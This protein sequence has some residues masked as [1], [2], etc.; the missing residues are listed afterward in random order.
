MFFILSFNIHSPLSSEGRS[1]R[2]R[3]SRY[4]LQSLEKKGEAG[5]S[6]QLVERTVVEQTLTL[7]SM[8]NPTLA[9]VDMTQKKLHP[10]R[11]LR[12]A[13]SWKELW[14]WT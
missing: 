10:W 11:A 1:V 12:G 13:G 14:A 9:Q 2:L 3:G 8:E 7:Q 5:I 6:L 4:S